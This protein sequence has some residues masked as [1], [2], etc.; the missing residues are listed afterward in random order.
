MKKINKIFKIKTIEEM[1]K[2]KEHDNMEII[3]NKNN[4]NI[5]LNEEKIS[6]EEDSIEVL[7]SEF[8]SNKCDSFK[9]KYDKKCNNFI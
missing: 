5:N 1:N 6:E 8:E 7:T 3:K 9:H 4:E 2:L